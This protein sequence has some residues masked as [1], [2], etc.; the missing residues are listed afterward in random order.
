MSLGSAG[1]RARRGSVQGKLSS[2]ISLVDAIPAIAAVGEQSNSAAHL[3]D[4]SPTLGNS[5]TAQEN[6]VSGSIEVLSST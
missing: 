5:P 4:T 6:R 1:P 2:C 3:L